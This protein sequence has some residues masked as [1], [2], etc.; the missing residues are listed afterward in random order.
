MADRPVPEVTI[1]DRLVRDLLAAQRPELAHLPIAELARGWDNTN[2]R[3]GDDLVVRVPHRSE[4]VPLIELEHRWV[5]A[6]AHMV[7]LS[8]PIPLHAGLPCDQFSWPWSI[9]PWFDGTHLA[10]ATL[11]DKRVEAA[12]FA[13][14]LNQLHQ[15]SPHDLQTSTIRGCPLDDRRSSFENAISAAAQYLDPAAARALFDQAVMA[16]PASHLTWVH[17]DLHSRNIIVDNHE[18]VAVIDWGDVCAGDRA[19]DLAAA[20]MVAPDHVDLILEH[21]MADDDTRHRAL[22]WAT[23]FAVIY[24]AH[25]DDDPEQLRI[26][27]NLWLTL[28]DEL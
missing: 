18:L 12:R 17:G 10:A 8:V 13:S 20:W 1:D 11:A 23:Y 27:H 9:V 15:P 24:L 3:L 6:V 14:F 19:T 5:P 22:G 28:T 21:C 4:A 26:G 25:S 16:A 7:E 2:F